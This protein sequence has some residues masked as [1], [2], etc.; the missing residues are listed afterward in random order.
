MKFDSVGLWKHAEN[1]AYF[2]DKTINAMMAKNEPKTNVESVINSIMH[3]DGDCTKSAF[4]MA[5][6]SVIEHTTLH[7]PSFKEAMKYALALPEKG[8]DI[9]DNMTFSYFATLVQFNVACYKN[10]WKMKDN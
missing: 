3:I 6:T 10:E 8:E 1:I 9:N 4:V 7:S 5:C 2:I